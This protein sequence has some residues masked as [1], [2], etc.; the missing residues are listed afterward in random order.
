MSFLKNFPGEV[1]AG[2]LILTW[3]TTMSSSALARQPRDPCDYVNPFIGTGGHGHTY[4][5]AT[6]PFGMVQLSPD[7]FNHGWDWCSGYHWSDDSMLG[8]SHTHLSG[9]GCGD[10]GDVLFAPTTGAINLVPGTREEP[11]KGY[12]SRF[13]HADEKASPGYYSVLLKTHGIK[14]ELTTTQHVGVH[15]YTF[16]QTKE[17]NIIIDL[18]HGIDDKPIELKLDIV[19]DQTIT[20]MRRSKGWAQDQYVFFAAKFSKP[21]RSFGTTEDEKE[22]QTG[23]RSS[24]G[25]K[26]KGWVTFDAQDGQP[27]LAKVALSTASVE[28]ALKNL[29]AETPDWNFDS[30]KDRARAAWNQE[31]S[32]IDV[33]VPTAALPTAALPTAALPTAA[34]PMV[35]VPMVP[36]ESGVEVP[37]VEG[38][39]TKDLETFYTA[40]YHV[41]LA[42]TLISDRDGAYRGSDHEVH[43]ADG[44]KVYSTFSLWDTFRAEQP[45]FTL[46]TPK[47]VNDMIRSFHLQAE[48]HKDKTLPIWPLAANETYCMIGYHSFPVIAEAYAK[49]IRD[50]D[51][52]AMLDLM[53]A[54]SE[55]NDWWADKGYIPQNKEAE[56][57]SKTLEFA[58]DDW[59]LAQFAGAL[60]NTAAHDKFL[61]R[62]MNYKN[63]FDQ[64]TGF[65][66]PKLE[67]GSWLTPFDPS[68]IPEKRRDFTEGNA[69]QYTWFVPHDVQGLINLMG[70]REAFVKKLDDFFQQAPSAQAAKLQDMTGLIGQYAQGNEPSHHVAYLYCYAG[71]PSKTQDRV[72]TIVKEFYDN[73]PQGLCGN[74]DC[75]QMSAW[76][77]FS[78]LG[79]YPVN[80]V[81]GTYV[82]GVPA[83]RKAA[84]HLPNEHT[85]T[86]VADKLSP[87][88]PYVEAVLLNG[89]PLERVYL[90]HKE[91]VEGGTLEFKMCSKSDSKWGTKP[92]DAP[93]SMSREQ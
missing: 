62:S 2:L 89:K 70:G 13:S 24:Q 78:T 93:P 82:L 40:L 45:L 54:N 17:A 38:A 41:F 65:M 27:I 73:T 7:T 77:I 51:A 35:A 37:P 34:A 74:E 55:G 79:F 29:S 58:Y 48:Y 68:S 83:F 8:F 22:R 49:G 92:I 33:E 14:A 91:I 12:R 80:P 28:G 42:P 72:R 59:A 19:D 56:S 31:L 3:I 52:Q 81:E 39:S 47:S 26:T 4:P 23:N 18:V 36:E 53:R 11:E 67:D 32:K 20:G 64:T 90:T 43:S 44:S 71:V 66:R 21:F 1:L 76:Y 25:T 57:V 85:L 9:T 5:G 87:Q 69:W 6:V 46:L 61:K 60:G 88:C 75:G 50:W 86:V 16:P 10:L 63:L 30:F 15:R 84:I